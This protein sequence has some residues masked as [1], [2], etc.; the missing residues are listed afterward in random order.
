MMIR[1]PEII[2]PGA[3]LRRAVN[4]R[5]GGP[6]ATHTALL[7]SCLMLLWSCL[8]VKSKA[9]PSRP[10]SRLEIAPKVHLV[11]KD[12]EGE[13]SALVCS[14]GARCP[15][16]GRCCPGCVNGRVCKRRGGAIAE[17]IFSSASPTHVKPVALFCYHVQRKLLREGIQPSR[18]CR[19]SASASLHARAVP[20]QIEMAE[21]GGPS[22]GL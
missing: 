19:I 9:I 22:P 15:M 21:A 12:G 10:R 3:W 8:A 16:G 20:P 13:M 2:A 5:R 7:L 6:P 17:I 1:W 4:G 18:Q 11:L 14:G